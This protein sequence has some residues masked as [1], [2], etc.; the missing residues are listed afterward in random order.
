[1]I[2]ALLVLLL[3]IVGVD[4]GRLWRTGCRP[5]L[6]LKRGVRKGWGWGRVER[7]GGCGG[8]FFV[9]IGDDIDSAARLG[10]TLAT[11]TSGQRLRIVHH[12]GGSR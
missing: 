6:R 4:G 12:V 2:I 1:M 10:E 3:E 5:V 7:W 11:S 9:G 8:G